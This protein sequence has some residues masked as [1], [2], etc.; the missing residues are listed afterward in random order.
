MELDNSG[1]YV[2]AFMLTPM[3][4]LQG[5][6]PAQTV[7]GASACLDDGCM[8]MCQELMVQ[9][10]SDVVEPAIMVDLIKV[11]SSRDTF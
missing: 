10:K 9:Q 4:M 11:R 5:L 3:C 2:F 1:L 8:Q 6:K 7:V